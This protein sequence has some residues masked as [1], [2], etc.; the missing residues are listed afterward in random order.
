MDPGILESWNPFGLK[1]K[2]KSSAKADGLRGQEFP[3]KVNGAF[4]KMI[5]GTL[6]TDCTNL[7][8][9]FLNK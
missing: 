2:L 1:S 8:S 6:F 5:C 9:T 7:K 3:V 4:D